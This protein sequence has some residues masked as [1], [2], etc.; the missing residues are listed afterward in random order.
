MRFLLLFSAFTGLIQYP[1]EVIHWHYAHR[2]MK[3]IVFAV[4]GIAEFTIEGV[5]GLK[6]TYRLDRPD[7]G[8]YISRL[9]RRTIKFSDNAVLVYMASLEYTQ[10]L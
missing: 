6:T 3:Q 5:K 7:L 10:E 4:A 2:E 9:H 8:L 1:E